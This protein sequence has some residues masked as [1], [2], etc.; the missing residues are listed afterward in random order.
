[1]DVYVCESK[2]FTEGVSINDHGEWS[3]FFGGRPT[4]MA[5]PIEQSQR[6]ITVLDRVFDA[7]LVALP[8]RLGLVSIKPDYLN[9][10]LVSNG[11]RIRRP[12]TKVAGMDSVMKIERFHA[13]ILERFDRQSNVATLLEVG[14]VVG[15][16]TIERIGRELVALHRPG[17]TDWA[18]YF[19]LSPPPS[20]TDSIGPPPKR[21]LRC[22]RCDTS[23]SYAVAKF[24]W[25]NKPR[26]GGSVYCMPCQKLVST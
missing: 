23:V 6:H 22:T 21:G 9:V 24:C 4:G 19:G 3:R 17:T 12:Q 18:A 16:D 5:S 1:M 13:W 15:R 7:G 26:F 8:R 20:P 25:V 14:R 11:A 10:V 2:H